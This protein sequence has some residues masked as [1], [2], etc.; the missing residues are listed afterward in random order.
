M[1]GILSAEASFCFLLANISW[2]FLR[3][4]VIKYELDDNKK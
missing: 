1:N 2:C 4:Q 3:V